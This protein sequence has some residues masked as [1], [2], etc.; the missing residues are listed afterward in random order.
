LLFELFQ[1]LFDLVD[2]T[3]IQEVLTRPPQELIKGLKG[4]LVEL[5]ALEGPKNVYIVHSKLE[6]SSFDGLRD[7]GSDGETGGVPQD[8]IGTIM[9]LDGQRRVDCWLLGDGG[10]AMVKLGRFAK[11]APPMIIPF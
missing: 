2:L 11:D 8:L 6:V 10:C 1:I 9:L 4:L 3:L 5:F 7:A